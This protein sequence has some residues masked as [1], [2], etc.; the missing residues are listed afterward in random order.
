MDDY[1]VGGFHCFGQGGRMMIH[2]EFN[3]SDTAGFYPIVFVVDSGA[4]TGLMSRDSY[5]NW[6]RSY[7]PLNPVLS[8]FTSVDERPLRNILGIFE[9]KIDFCSN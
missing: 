9:S 8:Q 2:H 7:F 4:N 6:F 5:D 1:D 3:I